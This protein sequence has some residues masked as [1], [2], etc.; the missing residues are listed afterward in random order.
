M[1]KAKCI[2]TAIL[3]TMSCF[4]GPAYGLEEDVICP[5]GLRMTISTHKSSRHN[6]MSPRRN[7]EDVTV[8]PGQKLKIYVTV[9]NTNTSIE[10]EDASVGLYLGDGVSYYKTFSRSD[11][12]S[13]FPVT[14]E[15]TLLWDNL[16]PMTSEKTRTFGVIL[17][18]GECIPDETQVQLSGIFLLGDGTTTC[19]VSGRRLTLKVKKALKRKRK[20]TTPP[21]VGNFG[22]LCTSN[23]GCGVEAG[24]V[25]NGGRCVY[26]LGAVNDQCTED[27]TCGS[28]NNC[29]EGVCQYCARIGQ[30]CGPPEACPGE[31]IRCKDFE[32]PDEDYNA[33]C[34]Y[35]LFQGRFLQCQIIY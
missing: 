19:G 26:P 10:V 4:M 28:G 13:P 7:N 30:L 29:I 11:K 14:H 20:C 35:Q 27:G 34:Q 16:G 32:F 31:E 24:L 23:T 18:L 25:C 6:T 8:K 17:A 2:L 15:S 1:Y 9:S 33:V 3:A 5:S 12:S 22:D 21:E